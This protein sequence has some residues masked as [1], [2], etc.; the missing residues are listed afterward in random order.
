MP[1]VQRPETG[2]SS[3]PNR[4]KVGPILSNFKEHQYAVHACCLFCGEIDLRFSARSGLLTGGLMVE[5]LAW[6]SRRSSRGGAEVDRTE[7][8]KVCWRWRQQAKKRGS[9]IWVGVG[10][11]VHF[12]NGCQ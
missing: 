3:R 5:S 6:K 10:G 9:A 7:V 8:G 4:L 2:S 1:K 12:L 11:V